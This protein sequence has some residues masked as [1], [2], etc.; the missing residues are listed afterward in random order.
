MYCPCNG[1][2][3]YYDL[4]IALEEVG[5]IT[6]KILFFVDPS[7]SFERWDQVKHDQDW[8]RSDQKNFAPTFV[9]NKIWTK[10]WLP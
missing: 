1:Y 5:L 8:I 3:F 7:H 2:R 6:L 10:K 9:S 4:S